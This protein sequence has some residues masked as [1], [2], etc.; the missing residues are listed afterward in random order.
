MCA[1]VIEFRVI[2]NFK[3]PL[4]AP[5][6]LKPLDSPHP[7]PHASLLWKH[8]CLISKRKT[9]CAS[10]FV[11]SSNRPLPPI[12]LWALSFFFSFLNEWLCDLSA[13]CCKL[14]VDVSD[15]LTGMIGWRWVSVVTVCAVF[16]SFSCSVRVYYSMTLSTVLTGFALYKVY[17]LLLLLTLKNDKRHVLYR[18]LRHFPLESRVWCHPPTH[19]H[20]HTPTPTPTH[21]PPTHTHSRTHARSRAGTHTV[22]YAC[23][24]TAC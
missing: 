21:T 17:I 6:S 23:K 2:K 10:I 18:S 8:T 20:T 19:T 24:S 11:W 1:A 4:S 3:P 7:S 14:P 15:G 5:L 9:F 22:A 16:F 12:A 13:C